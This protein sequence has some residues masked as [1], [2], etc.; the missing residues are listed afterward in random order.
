M[1]TFD[2]SL[3]STAGKHSNCILTYSRRLKWDPSI[4]LCSLQRGTSDE[5][6]NVPT[7]ISASAAPHAVFHAVFHHGTNLN[8]ARDT[9]HQILTLQ[10]R[11]QD[12]SA[13]ES[14][15]IENTFCQRFGHR[16]FIT[17]IRKQIKIYICHLWD[18]PL[19]ATVI[20]WMY[21]RCISQWT[22]SNAKRETTSVTNFF[23]H[24]PW[25]EFQGTAMKCCFPYLL[26]LL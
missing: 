18:N 6:I 20:P 12:H 10:V 19:F 3:F 7:L 11:R 8:V 24:R 13:I 26:T 21:I 16:G 9:A 1:R 14:D 5:E 25:L 2:S 22:S 23:R 15:K 17:E 4:P